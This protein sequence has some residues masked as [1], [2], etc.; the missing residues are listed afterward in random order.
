MYLEIL[1]LAPSVKG[2]IC[3]KYHM[4]P[5]GSLTA[6]QA[7]HQTWWQRRQYEFQDLNGLASLVGTLTDREIMILGEWNG[8]QSPDG[9]V[10]R[11]WRVDPKKAAPPSYQDR[12]QHV[13]PIDLDGRQ[14]PAGYGWHD[15]TALATAVWRELQ[16]ECI[17]LRNAGCVWYRSGSA[18]LPGK[19]H[20]ARLRFLVI[21][22]QPLE[23]YSRVEF[24]KSVKGA[25]QSVGRRVHEIY[26]PSRVC[27]GFDDPLAA[28]PMGGVID[29]GT[30]TVPVLQEPVRMPTGPVTL[31]DHTSPEGARILKDM[32]LKLAATPEGGD[33]DGG[34][35]R[36]AACLAT[37][38]TIGGYVGSGAIALNDARAELHAAVQ[39]F[40]DPDARMRAID[41]KLDEGVREPLPLGPVT[42]ADQFGGAAPTPPV[43]M[44]GAV[45][46]P[47]MTR[48]QALVDQ[49]RCVTAD[50][51]ALDGMVT[52]LARMPRSERMEVMQEAEILNPP[53][54]EALEAGVA[55]EHNQLKQDRSQQM[56]DSEHRKTLDQ[57]VFIENGGG[58]DGRAAI[59]EPKTGQRKSVSAFHETF[60]NM[61]TMVIGQDPSGKDIREMVTKYWVNNDA[62]RYHSLVFD[63][64][65][66][67]EFWDTDSGQYVFNSYRPTHEVVPVA[68]DISPYLH[69]LRS[70]FPDAGDQH[71]LLSA[72]AFAIQKP[73]HLLRW[74]PVLQGTHG[75]GKGMLIEPAVHAAGIRYTTIPSPA[76]LTEEKNG[77][78]GTGTV[79]FVDEIG[80]HRKATIKEIADR[81]KTLV[82]SDYIAVRAMGKD[83]TMSRNFANWF[84]ATNHLDSMLANDPRERRYAPLISVLQ[85]PE[86]VAAAFPVSLWGDA[87]GPGDDWF[88]CF[89]RWWHDGGAEAVRAFLMTYEVAKPGR[90]PETSTKAQAVAAGQDEMVRLVREAIEAGEP[91][92]RGGFVSAAAVRDLLESEGMRTPSGKYFAANMRTLGY[93]NHVR[94]RLTPGDS[95]LFPEF[96]TTAR[97]CI[98]YRDGAAPEGLKPAQVGTAYDQAQ[99]E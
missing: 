10:T 39:G 23:E 72:L 63:P 36:H 66:P 99:T 87:A 16:S 90:A 5:D 2:T 34:R 18:G 98:Y 60:T 96:K 85:E 51:P 75:C 22:E 61:G 44:P 77:W 3:K 55:T 48:A 65:M 24:L 78:L 88:S 37:A 80:E 70:N 46:M 9:L 79:V 31:S 33:A 52:T 76:Q 29:G 8:N 13:I 64:R 1:G 58:A 11:R 35:G 59:Y 21:N 47:G 93:R 40:N 62:P 43:T 25:D 81:L 27:M 30:A 45:A 20:E 92:F 32:A 53:V 54:A 19:E 6:I 69:I 71:V 86:D 84:F 57:F 42:L 91:G 50:D 28:Q 14:I 17:A 15:V 68:G 56:Y 74:A 83:T 95:L 26:G 94:I 49:T 38:K 4:Q 73:G 89:M 41:D 67:Q 7:D 82:A 97:L 12:A